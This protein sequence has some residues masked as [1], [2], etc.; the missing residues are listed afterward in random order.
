MFQDDVDKSVT[1]APVAA[2]H[3]PDCH[4]LLPH[5]NIH[6]V[7]HVAVH[8]GSARRWSRILLVCLETDNDW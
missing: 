1:P 5:A 7:Q 3:H 2:T 4:Q 6:D 8:L